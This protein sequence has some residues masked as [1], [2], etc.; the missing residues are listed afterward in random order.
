LSE[1]PP[2]FVALAY[3]EDGEIEAMSH[4]DRP[5]EGWMWHPE[6]EKILSLNDINRL[7][8]LLT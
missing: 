6:R 7:I 4:K 5:W 3:S 8:G 2:N 1:L